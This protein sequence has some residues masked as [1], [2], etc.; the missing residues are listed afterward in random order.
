MNHPK[1]RN[2]PLKK[3]IGL[4]LLLVLPMIMTGCGYSAHG[5]YTDKYQTVATPFF[6]NRT[7][8]R[9]LEADLSEAVAKEVES[10]TPYKIASPA[11][12]DTVLQGTITQF[13]Q[14]VLIRRRNGNV[15]EQMEVQMT[16]DFEWK[17]LRTG[18]T[19][20][21][22]KGY[23]AIGRYTPSNPVSQVFDIGQH[24]VAARMAEQ[25]IS[26]MQIEWLPD[27]DKSSA[28]SE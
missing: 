27:D 10:R 25:M 15:P 6:E 19:I 20:V 18:Q 2:Q 14:Q 1:A 3:A 24:R 22:R 13:Q 26:T 4:L 16:I 17:D 5:I 7:D 9:G 21:N 11:S 28:K 8:Y 12:A 23:Q